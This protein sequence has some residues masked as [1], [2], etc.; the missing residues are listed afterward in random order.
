[1][2]FVPQPPW[3]QDYSVKDNILFGYPFDQGRYKKLLQAGA[4]N[5]D[6]HAFAGGDF[7]HAGT[8]QGSALSGGQ[9]W[10]VALAR[11]LSSPAEILVLEDI[12]GVI[13]APIAIWI[14]NHALSGE[15]YIYVGIKKIIYL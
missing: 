13:D 9:N 12:L 11:A 6:L 7:A 3:I 1:M 4:L 15:M 8:A 2:S 10:R 14:C 5:Q